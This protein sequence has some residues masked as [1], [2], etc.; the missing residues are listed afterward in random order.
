MPCPVISARPSP[1]LPLAIIDAAAAVVRAKSSAWPLPLACR[2]WQSEKC[3]TRHRHVSQIGGKTS[4]PAAC[5]RATPSRQLPIELAREKRIYV[6]APSAKVRPPDPRPRYGFPPANAG[7]LGAA[8]S[9]LLFVKF[10]R[11]PRCTR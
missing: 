11:S 5:L 10:V 7:A 3:L 1:Q 8:G 9:V 2:S 4:D 6:T